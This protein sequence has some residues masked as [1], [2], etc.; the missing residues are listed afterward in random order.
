MDP[1]QKALAREYTARINKV[2]D[3]IE[4]T[5]DR[6]FTLEELAGVASF[7]KFHF[8][9]IF[10]AMTGES[11]FRYIQR[12]RI[13]RAAM[14]LIIT[15]H[16]T[17]GDIALN[18]GFSDASVF[19]R[20]FRDYFGM[21]AT[22]WRRRK[23]TPE[24]NPYQKESNPGQ[25]GSNLNQ[26]P[27]ETS[28]YFC[29]D[30]KTLKWRTTMKQMKNAEVKQL[31][32]TTLA[33]IRYTGPYQGDEKLFET[34]WG[35]ICGWAGPRGLLGRP[36]TQFIVIYHDDPNVT[37]PEKLRM[38]VCVSVPED[39]KVDGDIGKTDLE[40]GQYLVALFDIDAT[41]FPQAWGWVYG[42]WLPT[43]GYQ[44]ADGPCFERYV[45]E[46]KDGRFLVE[47]CVPVK[48]F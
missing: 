11:P 4:K 15:P 25:T 43:S 45:Q 48:P 21:S 41:Q 40:A 2:I 13:Q 30:T 35:R 20:C 22:M 3:Y 8:N 17:V 29:A 34:L 10:L 5:I 46:P 16:R 33:Y 7:S 47:I 23:M 38:S 37:E 18:C 9:R 12:I 6:P 31:P 32:K 19:S 26:F 28:I 14:Q 1:Q 24:G 39:T 36:E 44:P 42:S 27:P